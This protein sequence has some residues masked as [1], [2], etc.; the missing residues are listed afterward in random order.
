ML[1]RDLAMAL[2]PVRL[3]AAGAIAADPWQAELLRSGA[4]RALLLCSRQAGKSTVVAA[5]AAHEA[6]YRAP[7]L[8]LLLSPSLRQSQELFRKVAAFLAALPG[9]AID[10]D[11]TSLKVELANGSRLLALPGKEETIR[12][13]S[14]VRLLVIDEAARVPDAL[15]HAVRPMLAVSGGRLVALTTPW[16]KRGF[17]FHEWT[18]G[19]P[20]WRRVRVTAPECPR[21]SPAFLEGERRALP[22]SV[23]A[24][25]YLCE[26]RETD[27]QVFSY[28]QVAALV[29]GNVAPLFAPS[30]GPAP[31]RGGG[32]L[33]LFGG[34]V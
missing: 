14:G 13:Y 11:E 2:D 29:S 32:V 3:L 34:G 1:A 33:P 5:L 24:Q 16:G 27:D 28:D 15:Y 26:F 10:G 22:E 31:E 4:D 17:F 7:A 23:Y 8:V 20:S 6:M 18:E 12:G 25:E 30:E 9:F 19:G 21:I